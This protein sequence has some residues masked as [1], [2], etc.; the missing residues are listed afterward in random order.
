MMDVIFFGCVVETLTIACRLGPEKTLQKAL[1][2]LNKQISLTSNE[3]WTKFNNI[4]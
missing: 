3:K 4:R 1:L 2:Y